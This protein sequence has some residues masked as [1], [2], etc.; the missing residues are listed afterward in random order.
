MHTQSIE[1][2]EWM[3]AAQTARYLNMSY[4]WLAHA[5]RGK[6]DG[7]PF[8]YVAA[9]SPRYHRPTL[10]AWMQARSVTMATPRKHKRKRAK[11]KAPSKT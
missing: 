10:D 11:R 1:Y 7:P 8:S 9:N 5:R 3:T 2:P 6:F 4:T